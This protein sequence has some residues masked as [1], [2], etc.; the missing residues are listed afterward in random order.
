VG[1][2][3]CRLRCGARGC[4]LI[5]WPA[6]LA[7]LTAIERAP[8]PDPVS[9][10]AWRDLPP[11]RGADIDVLFVD[12]PPPRSLPALPEAPYTA[13]PNRAQRRAKRRNQR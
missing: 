9:A 6:L 12:D 10:D 2:P 8:R 13:P 5:R 3:R 4:D 7:A 11:L 1:R